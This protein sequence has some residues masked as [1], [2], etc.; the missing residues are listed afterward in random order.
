MARFFASIQGQKT[1]PLTRSDGTLI[2]GHIRGWT[3]G[4]RIVINVDKTGENHVYIYRTHGSEGT[5]KKDTLI[6]DYTATHVSFG[7]DGSPLPWVI[8]TGRC[9]ADP[10]LRVKRGGKT[11]THPVKL[12]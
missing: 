6:V 9:E 1:K 4:C 3:V 7:P 2:F 8:A 12:P 10:V 11:I 5:G